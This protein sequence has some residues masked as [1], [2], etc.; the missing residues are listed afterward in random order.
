MKIDDVFGFRSDHHQEIMM[1]SFDE[2]H[3]RY[4]FTAELQFNMTMKKASVDEKSVPDDVCIFGYKTVDGDEKVHRFNCGNNDGEILPLLLF[5]K[6]KLIESGM[7]W[8][9]QI[10]TLPQNSNRRF[11]LLL[12]PAPR[13]SRQPGMSTK[14]SVTGSTR[15]RARRSFAST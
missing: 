13:T 6:F 3:Q 8:G 4:P 7:A 15:W 9:K 10:S 2:L 5:S 14:T 1:L 12:T 11:D